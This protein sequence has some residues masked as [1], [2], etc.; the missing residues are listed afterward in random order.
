[1]RKPALQFPNYLQSSASLVQ[2]I[3]LRARNEQSM[4]S[5]LFD[6]IIAIGIEFTCPAKWSE[7]QTVE[8]ELA[9]EINYQF[10][11]DTRASERE[12]R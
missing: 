2:K 9:Q 6:L 5:T 3:H 8:T 1:M 11:A 7:G 10:E 4:R 12:V